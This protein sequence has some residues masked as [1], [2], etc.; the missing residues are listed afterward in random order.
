MLP[1]KLGLLTVDEHANPTKRRSY[2]RKFRIGAVLSS[3]QIPR[4]SYTSN[5]D[6][7]NH[8][9]NTHDQENIKDMEGGVPF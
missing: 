9:R 5:D 3:L 4:F 1:A 7:P 8:N 6:T 2:R